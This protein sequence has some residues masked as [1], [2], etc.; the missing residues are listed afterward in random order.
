VTSRRRP[1]SAVGTIIPTL[2]TAHIRN[3]LAKS[4]AHR[5]AANGSFG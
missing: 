4:T 2:I 5:I 3:I 1:G